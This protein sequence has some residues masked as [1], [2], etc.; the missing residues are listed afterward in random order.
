MTYL[1]PNSPINTESEALRAARASAIAIFI[2]VVVG[3]IGAVWMLMNPQIV[4]DAVAQAEAQTP[5]AGA[6][7]ESGAMF[8]QYFGYAIILIQLVLGFIQWRSPNKIIAFIFMALI[9]LGFLMTA[10]TPLFANMAPNMPATPVWQIALSLIVM[11]VQFVLH[12]T[13]VKG[14]SKLNQLQMDAAR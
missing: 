6:V 10:A 14:I 5:G 2:G 8:G 13:G 7:A 4:A 11:V 12:L 9:V 1:L 3:I